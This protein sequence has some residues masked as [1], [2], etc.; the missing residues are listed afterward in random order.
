M[1]SNRSLRPIFKLHDIFLRITPAA[2][3]GYCDDI[4]L[5]ASSKRD[6][7]ELLNVC[8]GYARKWKMEF[9][10]SKS[11]YIC[12]GNKMKPEQVTMNDCQIP[13]TSE[14][15]YLGLPVGNTE[16]KRK[17]IEKK[18]KKVEK[19]FYSLYSLGCRPQGVNPMTM[20]YLYKQY[21]QAIFK[22]GLELLYINKSDLDA[23][24]KRQNILIKRSIGLCK[25]TKTSPLFHALKIESI[26]A[27]YIKHK[28]F[29]IRQFKKN[30]ITNGIYNILKKYYDT[31]VLRLNNDSFFGQL[32]AANKSVGMDISLDLNKSIKFICLGQKE[33]ME[34]IIDSIRSILG[35]FTDPI[36]MY[37]R[38]N[39]L[40][41]ILNYNNYENNLQNTF[42]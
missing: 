34:G 2:Q 7:N 28:I 23:Y 6:M 4:M 36:E 13:H 15:I 30:N 1:P 41:L 27:I 38:T 9:N 17:F 42:R 8:Q 12:F 24:N 22:Y 11:N 19:S 25:Y 21:C 20:A 40:K 5:M 18:F 35:N 16:D 14:F 37:N 39:L 29:A 33:C 10:P 32:T 31:K 26:N 3:I